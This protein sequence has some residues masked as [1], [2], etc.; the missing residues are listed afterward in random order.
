ML[1]TSVNPS[2]IVSQSMDWLMSLMR[3]DI[4]VFGVFVDDDTEI[5][6]EKTTPT[7]TLRFFT[8]ERAEFA[9]DYLRDIPN[10][11]S[12]RSRRRVSYTATHLQNTK[13]VP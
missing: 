6:M 10:W 1:F 13:K 8:N 11:D 12:E 9:A 3:S 4:V 2:D 7:L 5:Y